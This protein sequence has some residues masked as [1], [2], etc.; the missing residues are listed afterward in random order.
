MRIRW[1]IVC[2]C[3][4][5]LFPSVAAATEMDASAYLSDLHLEEIDEATEQY[6]EDTSFSE[7][8]QGI[9]DGSITFSAEDWLDRGFEMAFGE[10]R[11]QTGLVIQLLAV[12]IL[13]AILRQIS[14]S[15]CGKE[16][17][18]MGFY[19]CYMILIVVLIS[20]FFEITEAVV[21]RVGQT[22]DAF[23][24]ML[25][26]FLALAAS[27]G[28]LTQTALMGPTMMGGCTLIAFLTKTIIVP[29]ILVA[30]ALEMT[31]KLSEQPL[32]ERFAKLW[33]QGISWGMKGLAGGFMLLLS[34]QK[35]GGGALNG[36]AVR[37]AKIA[38]NA[39]PIVGDVMGGAVD[40]AAAVASTLRG[41][42]LAA[43]I[44]FFLLLC[45][46]LLCKLIVMT[47][48]FKFTAAA[49]ESICEAR[50]VSC[51]GVAGD[52]TALLL[53]VVFLVEVMFLFS[54]FLLLG[55]V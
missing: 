16:V 25:P 29:V 19:V 24:V 36:L 34:L 20:T 54:A 5:L 4:L 33:K 44:L 17:G 53:G 27:S 32:C 31:D 11:T 37:T 30:V 46:P 50:L 45:L 51:I 22:A 21:E 9:L 3:C 35:I 43:A 40:T 18:E 38:V 39:V 2:C 49:T 1:M 48:I 8:V 13:A 6:L 42:T 26:V 15:F 12:S 55:S 41:G 52:Y 7:L 47:L 14:G 23:A 10:I 28:N